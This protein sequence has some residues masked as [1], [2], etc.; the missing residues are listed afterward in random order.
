MHL[1]GSTGLYGAERWILA[2]LNAF[3]GQEVHSTLVNLVDRDG[4]QSAVVSI[5]RQQGKKAFDFN[6]GGKFNLFAALRLARLIKAE[7]VQIIHGHGF[8]SDILGLLAARLAGCPVLT[9]PH[10]W[11][12]DDDWKLKMYERLDRFSFSFMDMVCP[13][14]PDLAA[15]LTGT[16]APA[17]MRLILNGVDIDEIRRASPAEKSHPDA[18]IIGYIGQLIERKDLP[19]LLTAFH[20]LRT[21]RDNL[22][23]IIIGDGP[24]RQG[25]EAECQRLGMSDQ[26]D[27]LGYRPDAASW[28][29]TFDLFVLPSQ[30]EGIP[31]CI[32][33]ALAAA[34]PV[35]A[36]DIPGNKDLVS[37]QLTGLLYP[38]GDSPELA[39]CISYMIDHPVEA[40]QMA[41]NGNLK[42]IAEYS[43]RKMA[44]EYATIYHSL[45]A[46]RK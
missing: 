13:L 38:V 21:E 45:A 24:A 9:T 23:L 32:M 40:R 27:F 10:G 41:K 19:T 4:D 46:A 1:I 2:L 30:L 15:G 17:K 37:H 44:A 11:S 16:I 42:V 3:T 8:K 20:S 14:S 39:R 31:R 28:L 18:F 26:I 29:K 34:I 43:N 5:A 36:T 35:V 22:R 12:L 25:L 33:E 6:T 7:G